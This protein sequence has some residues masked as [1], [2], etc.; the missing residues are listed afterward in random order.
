MEVDGEEEA[1]VATRRRARGLW[2]AEAPVAV[3]GA[4]GDAAS[5]GSVAGIGMALQASAWSE[6]A[7]RDVDNKAR[8]K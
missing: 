1:E 3:A 8:Q 4:G 6:T 5:S 2:D 7:G